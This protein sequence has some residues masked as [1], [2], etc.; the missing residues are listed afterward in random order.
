MDVTGSIGVLVRAVERSI[1]EPETADD[2]LS[3]WVEE[4]GYRSPT[5]DL[6]SFL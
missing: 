5:E 4:A 6:A 2:W 1:V 3:T